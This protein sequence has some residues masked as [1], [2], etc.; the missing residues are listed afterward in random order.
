MH[1][2]KYIAMYI[3]T[4]ATLI[5][6]TFTPSKFKSALATGGKYFNQWSGLA[7]LMRK[8]PVQSCYN[9]LQTHIM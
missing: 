5:L 3:R 7:N 4:I 8:F 6:V 9:F 2:S 1:N